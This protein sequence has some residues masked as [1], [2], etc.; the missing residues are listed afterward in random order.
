MYTK[1]IL[2]LIAYNYRL[3]KVLFRKKNTVGRVVKKSNPI[4]F[5]GIK[6]TMKIYV[7]AIAKNEEK[8]AAR[9]YESVKEADGVFVLDTGS[10]DDTV[11]ILE[12]SGA[13]VK[14]ENI[15]PWRFDTARNRA[16]SLVP[17][18]AD[19]CVSVDIDEVFLPGWRQ[20]LEKA[21]ADNPGANLFSCYY[22]WSQNKDGSDGITFYIKKIHRRSGFV[23]KGIVHEVVSPMPGVR[24]VECEIPGAKLIHMPDD[25]KSRAQYLPL[26]EQAVKE[27]PENDRN[28]FYLGREYYFRGKNAE[29]VRELTRHLA[30]PSAC[31]D[32]ERSASRRF[33]AN[34]YARLG[35]D[36][37]ALKSYIMSAG[38]YPFSR[39]PWIALGKYFYGKEN[40]EGVIF[41]IGEALKI[42]KPSTSYLND[43]ES[44]SS[45]PYDVLSIAYYKTGQVALAASAAERALSL[46]PDDARI[47][48]NLDF[49]R[50]NI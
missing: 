9:W 24:L 32:E 19:I 36:K 16:L 14:T 31:W 23:W 50:E 18:D 21:A 12:K 34:A 48:G 15:M 41:A 30:L 10:S 33:L 45:Y 49:F 47:R 6:I 1:T 46:S 5:S 40:W 2:F 4:A 7:Y 25:D 3:Q 22:A 35:D 29:C 13:I 39:E 38:E 8:F 44:F 27:D 37:N 28:S 17:D 26:L 42:E 11:K 20:K 43:P